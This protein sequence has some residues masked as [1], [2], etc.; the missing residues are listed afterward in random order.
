[1]DFIISFP[2][3]FEKLES[4]GS[5][6]ARYAISR[7]GIIT[8]EFG[9]DARCALCPA[10]APMISEMEIRTEIGV[11]IGEKVTQ[12]WEMMSN[13]T[14]GGGDEIRKLRSIMLKVMGW[15]DYLIWFLCYDI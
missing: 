1:M 2:Y 12:I 6:Y 11:K 10:C 14:S 3:I 7:Q 8:G 13:S 5:I 4:T 9:E 15:L